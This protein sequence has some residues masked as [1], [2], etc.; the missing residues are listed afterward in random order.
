MIQ[1]MNFKSG[2]KRTNKQQK[3]NNAEIE[4]QFLKSEGDSRFLSYLLSYL[5]LHLVRNV[6]VAYVADCEGRELH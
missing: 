6:E 4:Q 1:K 2:R 3:I 5:L